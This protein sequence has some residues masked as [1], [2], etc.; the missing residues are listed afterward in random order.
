MRATG[1]PRLSNSQTMPMPGWA[2]AALPLSSIAIRSGPR[3]GSLANRPAFVT[4]PLSPIGSI[5][6]SQE[7]VAA[8]KTTFSD[9]LSA[10]P[11]GLG[12]LST[13]SGIA[14]GSRIR[15]ARRGAE[16]AAT[17]R[18]RKQSRANPSLLKIPC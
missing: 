10:I 11:L 4:F 5:Q 14:S 6:I 15:A 16:F 18:W 7:R 2:T 12:T 3:L 13:T 8:T 9:L 17:L 1:R